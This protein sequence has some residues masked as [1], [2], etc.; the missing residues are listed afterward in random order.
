MMQ[1]FVKSVELHTLNV[2]GT[3][4]V[5]DIKHQVAALDDLSAA[6]IAMYCHGRPLEDS[7]IIS[8]FAKQQST[9]DVEI[10]L[11]GGNPSVIFS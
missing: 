8:A 5:A 3:E 6:D 1:L 11:L 10:R 4:T 2:A 9:F 7:E